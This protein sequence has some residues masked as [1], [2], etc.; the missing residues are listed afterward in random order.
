LI[1]PLANAAEEDVIIE[2]EN[3]L[4]PESDEEV[5]TSEFENA[6]EDVDTQVDILAP[7]ME[8]DLNPSAETVFDEA[9]DIEAMTEEEMS[10]IEAVSTTDDTEQVENMVMPEEEISE[11]S[12]TSDEYEEGKDASMP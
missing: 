6:S 1:T 3:M 7:D 8:L 11:P 9:I 5:T 10:E 4:S 2:L 12:A